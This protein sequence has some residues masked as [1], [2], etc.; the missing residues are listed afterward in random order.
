MAAAINNGKLT[1]HDRKTGM[2]RPLNRPEFFGLVT[3]E[4]VNKWLASTQAIYQWTPQTPAAQ[5]ATA[6]PDAP[7]VDVPA[8]EPC[9]AATGPRFILKNVAL[10]A[11]LEYEWSSIK[12]DISD[13]KRNGLKAAAHTGKH[14]E[15]DADKA[16]AWAVLK[17][18]VKQTAPVNQLASAWNGATTRHTISH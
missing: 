12:A 16:R 7:V 9:L 5:A 3:P 14:G 6:P 8:S 15:W 1:T 18:K 17:G 11:N 4:S 10:I 2:A 13:A